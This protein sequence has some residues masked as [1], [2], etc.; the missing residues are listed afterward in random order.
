M[1][2]AWWRRQR[3]P[4]DTHHDRR[5]GDVLI[6]PGALSEHALGDQQQHQ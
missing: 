1:D 6:A 4:H 5:H 2:V 3:G